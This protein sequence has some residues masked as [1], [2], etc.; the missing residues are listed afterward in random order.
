MMDSDFKSIYGEITRALV[1]EVDFLIAEDLKQLREAYL[2]ASVV[3]SE[4]PHTPLY[5]NFNLKSA[6]Q[7]K[8][9]DNLEQVIKA[10]EYYLE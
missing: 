7:I 6:T 3:Q 10:L 2:I 5:L 1:K 4:A 8:N 9:G